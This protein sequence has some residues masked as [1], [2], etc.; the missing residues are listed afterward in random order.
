MQCKAPWH[1]FSAL[2][3]RSWYWATF[4]A[5]KRKV[6]IEAEKLRLAGIKSRKQNYKRIERYVTRLE[7]FDAQF[8]HAWAFLRVQLLSALKPPPVWDK[9]LQ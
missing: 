8:S 4:Y 7:R 6:L 3:E 1:E 5:P 9:T 2:N